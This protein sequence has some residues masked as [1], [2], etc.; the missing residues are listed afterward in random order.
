[1]TFILIQL[2]ETKLRDLRKP[3]ASM[4]TLNVSDV[5]EDLSLP[6]L[7]E[8]LGRHVSSLQECA[9]KLVSYTEEISSL[10]L[11][12]RQMKYIS[13]AGKPLSFEL[14]RLFS[15]DAWRNCA[16]IT[17]LI[18]LIPGTSFEA[19]ENPVDNGSSGGRLM[20][21]FYDKGPAGHWPVK[22]FRVKS[23]KLLIRNEFYAKQKL[24]SNWTTLKSKVRNVFQRPDSDFLRRKLEFEKVE[25]T[26]KEERSREC[27][28][29][30]NKLGIFLKGLREGDSYQRFEREV[31]H[32]HLEGME[33]G[34]I[35]DGRYFV[36]ASVKV[37]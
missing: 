31:F 20:N 29:F 34:D 13:L 3:K 5:Q 16:D 33:V 4:D 15:E 18:D 35:N 25:Q 30:I 23:T 7:L 10:L 11:A 32:A 14:K 22:G 24:Y 6:K 12:E 9:P 19:D 26:Q 21:K 1:M 37:K 8:T 27:S 17:G 36:N 2:L 28:A